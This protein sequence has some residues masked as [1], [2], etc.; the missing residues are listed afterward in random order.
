DMCKKDYSCIRNF[1]CPAIMI[2]ENDRKTI[3]ST[4]LCNGCGV[5]SNLCPHGAIYKT[6]G[7]N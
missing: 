6:E 7:G 3:I 2:D 4:E 5:C 1:Y